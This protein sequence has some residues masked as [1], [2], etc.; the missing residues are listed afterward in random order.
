MAWK[1]PTLDTRFHIDWEWWQAHDRNFRYHLYDQLCPECRRRIPS[2][3]TVTEVDWIDP[4][5]AEVTRADPLAMCLRTRCMHEHDFLNEKLP[6]ATAVFRVFLMTDNRPAS[7][8]ELH[9]Y[10]PWRPPEAILSVIGGREVHYGIR[11]V[12]N[13]DALKPR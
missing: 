13:G 12:E 5:T 3:A 10:L 6:V 7:P 9:R 11:P 8:R 4:E 2:P 1:R